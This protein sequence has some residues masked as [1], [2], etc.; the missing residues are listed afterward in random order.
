MQRMTKGNCLGEPKMS[1]RCERCHHPRLD[2]WFLLVGHCDIH[3]CELACLLV[4]LNAHVLFWVGLSIKAPTFCLFTVIT[5]EWLGQMC[6]TRLCYRIPFLL[7]DLKLDRRIAHF[8]HIFH[9]NC[10]FY[11][12]EMRRLTWDACG[13]C[14]WA[15]GDTDDGQTIICSKSSLHPW[16]P[17]KLE[18]CLPLL[19]GVRNT[20][21]L[22]LVI[23]DGSLSAE[24][25]PNI[26]FRVALNLVCHV[27]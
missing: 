7:L 3:W 4:S 2:M 20:S 1:N 24:A 23:I 11:L 21:G 17:M 26:W 19:H 9:G 18:L 27:N 22:F 15:G 10:A 16:L 25:T 5:L 12:L 6:K 14:S 8:W 13:H